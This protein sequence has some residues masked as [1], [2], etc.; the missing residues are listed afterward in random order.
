LR[1]RPEILDEGCALVK[2]SG[3]LAACRAE[4]IQAVEEAWQ[5]LSLHLPPTRAKLMLRLFISKLLN[6]REI[7]N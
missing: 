1:D 5:D 7:G 2:K 3:A 6:S 4:A